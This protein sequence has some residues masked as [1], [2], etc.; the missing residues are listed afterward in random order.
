MG[1]IGIPDREAGEFPRA[2]VMKTPGANVTEEE[3]KAFVS[4]KSNVTKHLLE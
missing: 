3:L 1:V 4:G 2:F